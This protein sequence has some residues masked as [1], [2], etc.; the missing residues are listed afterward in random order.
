[1]VII[2]DK[3][4][5]PPYSL[6]KPDAPISPSS[7][8]AQLHPPPFVHPRKAIK[9][10]SLPQH[11]LFQ[12]VYTVCPE[13]LPFVQHRRRLYWV[14]T[15]LKL[16]SRGFYIASMHLLRSAY[17]PLYSSL[18]KQPYT[19]DPFP[20]SVNSHASCSTSSS[21]PE[22]RIQSLQRET[23]IL[24][25]FVALKVKEDVYADDTE[26]HLPDDDG[27]K[28]IFELMQPRSRLE[29]L[30][31]HYGLQ[32]GVISLQPMP[33]SSSSSSSTGLN[34]ETL[35]INFSPRKVSVMQID[36]NRRKKII[37]ELRRD[38]EESLELTAK[39][40][41]RELRELYGSLSL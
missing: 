41:V 29:D 30:L 15:Y 27:F 40:I 22:F 20:L 12:I 23:T 13:T 31:R 34:F 28:D 35:S 32:S 17:L 26:L 16:V 4:P 6:Q 19:S 3:Q 36:R 2:N 9:F 10:S 8:S 5:P 39:R 11:I 33:S 24:D 38:K 1:M 18:I 37:T 14:A 21:S 7:P 25:L